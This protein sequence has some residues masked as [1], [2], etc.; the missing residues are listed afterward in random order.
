MAGVWDGHSL[1]QFAPGVTYDVIEPLAQQLIAMDGAIEDRSTD[2]SFVVAADERSS[3]DEAI[4]TGGIHVVPAQDIA[5]D[6][7]HRPTSSRFKR[8]R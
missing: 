1:A 2:P 6:G 5:T 8:P 7:P 3:V 4:F